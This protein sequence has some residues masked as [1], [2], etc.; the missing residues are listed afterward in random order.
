[1]WFYQLT[2]GLQYLPTTS[3]LATTATARRQRT[4]SGGASANGISPCL[5]PSPLPPSTPLSHP[6]TPSSPPLSWRAKFISP[7]RR[8]RAI[9]VRPFSNRFYH[10]PVFLHLPIFPLLP[11][12]PPS[13]LPLPISSLPPH[14]TPAYQR[15]YIRETMHS[16]L[17]L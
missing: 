8:V 6:L 3:C 12:L 15:P 11:Y 4:D 13:S 5:P 14:L 2:L 16:A 7:V 10:F 1:M 17:N 9:A